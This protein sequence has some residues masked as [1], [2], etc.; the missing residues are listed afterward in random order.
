M[1]D[2]PKSAV[3]ICTRVVA[4]LLAVVNEI[5]KRPSPFRKKNKNKDPGAGTGEWKKKRSI[6]DNV[7]KRIG[8][9]C[10][11]FP[12]LAATHRHSSGN[13]LSME[14][15]LTWVWPAPHVSCC[16]ARTSI[17]FRMA[18]GG[19]F[20]VF[21]FFLNRNIYTFFSGILYIRVRHVEPSSFLSCVCF[22]KGKEQ[23]F[24]GSRCC[25]RS[26]SLGVPFPEAPAHTGK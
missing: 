13:Y 9:K 21:C 24:D 3:A 12:L 11:N 17:P 18:A 15:S 10:K 14:M 16:P 2:A 22:S 7:A 19:V 25:P 1:C 4:Q 6:A 8:A 23:E 5:D 20:F 26:I